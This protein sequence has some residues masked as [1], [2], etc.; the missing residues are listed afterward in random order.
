MVN[1]GFSG[2]PILILNIS[3]VKILYGMF[4]LPET[5]EQT[6]VMKK[7]LA[8]INDPKCLEWE[9]QQNAKD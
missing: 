8:F 6:R 7:V 5:N 1:T 9:Q 3:D 2:E 4:D